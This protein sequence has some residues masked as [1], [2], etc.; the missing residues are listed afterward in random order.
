M[1]VLSLLDAPESA[2]MTASGATDGDR[3]VAITTIAFQY[4]WMHV[5]LTYVL[6]VYH[7]MYSAVHYGIG[8]DLM[9]MISFQ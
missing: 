7:I 9:Q 2:A 8:S 1:I 6:N 4:P 3:A 5:W